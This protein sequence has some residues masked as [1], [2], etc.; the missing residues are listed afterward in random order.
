MTLADVKRLAVKK[1][2]TIHFRLGNGMECIVNNE[3]VAT[4]PEL[5]AAPGFKLEDELDAATEFLVEPALPAPP[6]KVARAEM[7][8]MTAASPTA[9]AAHD[10]DD[11]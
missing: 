1:H 8:S 9:A 2:L 11:E 5:K 3:G 7:M 4:I 6:K 10:H